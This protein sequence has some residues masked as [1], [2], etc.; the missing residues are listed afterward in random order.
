MMNH[1]IIDKKNT[2]QTADKL[3]NLPNVIPNVL[4]LIANQKAKEGRPGK[5]GRPPKKEKNHPKEA[6]EHP[7]YKPLFS[8]VTLSG[9]TTPSENGSTQTTQS[10]GLGSQVSSSHSVV[11]TYQLVGSK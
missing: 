5:P 9:S 7:T 6:K 10:K 3:K 2:T 4:P 1:V 11:N 8:N